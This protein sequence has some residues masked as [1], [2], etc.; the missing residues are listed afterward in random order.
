M[1]IMRLK[2][3]AANSDSVLNAIF[4]SFGVLWHGLSQEEYRK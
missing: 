4:I 2:K 1:L 3:K